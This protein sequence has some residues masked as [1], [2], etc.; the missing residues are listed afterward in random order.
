MEV[1][2][3]RHANHG[4]G[5]DGAISADSQREMQ[6]AGLCSETSGGGRMGFTAKRCVTTVLKQIF[7]CLFVCLFVA[8]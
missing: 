2:L 3:A 1:L 4:G 7:V 8:V 5:L 6:P